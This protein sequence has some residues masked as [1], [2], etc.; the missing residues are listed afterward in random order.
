VL[1]AEENIWLAQDLIA[2]LYDKGRSMITEHIQNIF[3]EGELSADSVCREFRRTGTDCKAYLLYPHR[4]LGDFPV[5][6]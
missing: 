4:V 5:L 6:W 1:Y 3:E 2:T